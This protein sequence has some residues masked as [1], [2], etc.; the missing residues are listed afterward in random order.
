VTNILEKE[1]TPVTTLSPNRSGQ[2]D[3][4]IKKLLAKSAEDRYA[5]AAGLCADLEALRAQQTRPT[6][7]GRMFGRFFATN[8]RQ[9][10][11][12]PA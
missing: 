10:P 11:T 2:L 12:R 8:P 9:P 6:L 5:S 4:I 3:R 1:P 7:F